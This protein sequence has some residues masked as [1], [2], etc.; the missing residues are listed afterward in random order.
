MVKYADADTKLES[1]RQAP[2]SKTM[3]DLFFSGFRFPSWR[4][5]HVAEA[6]QLNLAETP[7]HGALSLAPFRDGDLDV[8]VAINR[9]QIAILVPVPQLQVASSD[10][11]VDETGE[12]HVDAIDQALVRDVEL[13]NQS[14]VV[15]CVVVHFDLELV[16]H[17]DVRGRWHHP[18]A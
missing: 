5:A 14:K 9:D 18:M 3:N 11:A 10:A 8:I 17:A 2:P 16:R 7:W 13:C 15:A 6:E 12:L 4:L 1:C